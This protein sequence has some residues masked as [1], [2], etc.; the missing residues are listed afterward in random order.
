MPDARSS[1]PGGAGDGGA[2]RGNPSVPY[3]GSAGRGNGRWRTA[4]KPLRP[5]MARTPRRVS[6]ALGRTP[7]AT[8]R[9]WRLLGPEQKVAAAGAVL[10][11]I[12][13]L[14]PYSWVEAAE[15]TVAGAVLVLLKRRADRAA[16]HLPF[17]DGPVIAAA[18]A[19]AAILVLIRIPTRPLGQGLLALACAGLIAAAGLRERATRPADDVP[20]KPRRRDSRLGGR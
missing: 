4:P 17:G 10:L 15:L 14:G 13:T 7:A 1:E 9:T 6:A 20:T 8:V 18:G 11:A 12:S 19:W 5:A 2:H 3:N 16:F